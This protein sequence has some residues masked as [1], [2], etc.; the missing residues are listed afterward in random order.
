MR[1]TCPAVTGAGRA[2]VITHF[3]REVDSPMTVALLLD[4]SGSVA[5]I[6][7]TEKA[8]AARFF[9]E[10]LRPGDRALLV[11][12]ANLI[13][14]W[15]DLTTSIERLQ[16]ALQRAGPFADPAAIPEVRP[17]GGTLL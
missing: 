2:Q 13:A 3:A 5:G 17:R 7:G 16:R 15:Q 6:I 9:D 10:V 14:V 8:A 4:V 12:F 1:R 11:G